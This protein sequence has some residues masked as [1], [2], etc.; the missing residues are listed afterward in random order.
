ML[1]RQLALPASHVR[2]PCPEPDRWPGL[3]KVGVG[4]TAR[5][6]LQA[7][8]LVPP[9]EEGLTEAALPPA[10]PPLQSQKP[11][12]ASSLISIF[13]YPTFCKSF[14]AFLQPTFSMRYLLFCGLSQNGN[15]NV[16]TQVT[17]TL[18]EVVFLPLPQHALHPLSCGR[19][20]LP[21]SPARMGGLRRFLG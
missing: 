14:M 19:E 20:P 12:Q 11:F 5:K 21:S 4:G 9:G 17:F 15:Q 16:S 3:E 6:D 2:S 1:A 7:Y 10:P 13:L 18:F 8:T